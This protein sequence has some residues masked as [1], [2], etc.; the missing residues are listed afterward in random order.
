MNIEHFAVKNSFLQKYVDYY[1]LMST[2]GDEKDTTYL[3]FPSCNNPLGFCRNG[4]ISKTSDKFLVNHSSNQSLQTGLV[5]NFLKPLE[6]TFESGIVEFSIIFKPLAV[7]LLIKE[8]LGATLSENVFVTKSF[9]WLNSI[10]NKLIDGVD[11]FEALENALV[12]RISTNKNLELLEAIIRKF[13]N[14]ETP[15]TD[16]QVSEEFEI[17]A[18]Q[19][20]RLFKKHLGINPTQYRQLS[21]FRKALNLSLENLDEQS[22]TEIGLNAGYYDQPHFI[23]EFKKTTNLTPRDFLNKIS[24]EAND[25]IVWQFFSEVSESYN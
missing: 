24:L 6:I 13:E 23:K 7:N 25:K 17:S 4:L 21:R 22:L 8:S 5:G 3:A 14:S 11:E 12:S 20:F 10:V 15:F 1:Y 2:V 19:M 9:E 16:K 18:K